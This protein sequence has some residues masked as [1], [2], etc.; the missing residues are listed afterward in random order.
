MFLE[1]HCIKHSC[2]L[3]YL[4]EQLGKLRI[5]ILTLKIEKLSPKQIKDTVGSGWNW[6]S[7]PSKSICI[8]K[9]EFKC[10]S[11]IYFFL[12]FIL[13]LLFLFSETESGFVAKADHEL[14]TFL[15]QL[16]DYR[17]VPLCLASSLAFI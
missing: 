14:T 9:R 13:F 4:H 7:N 10:F 16:A 11:L 5:I 2:V 6:D 1:I 8:C 17:S 12:L 15:L 3:S